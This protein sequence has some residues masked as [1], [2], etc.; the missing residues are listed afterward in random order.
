MNHHATEISTLTKGAIILGH[1]LIGWI[2]CG[3]LIG[4]GRQFMSMQTTLVMHAIGAPL[5]FIIISLHYFKRFAFTSPLQAAFLFLAVVIAMDVFV[6]A[7]LIEK[8]FAMFASPL[9]TWLPLALIFSS[10]HMTGVI[11]KHGEK[12]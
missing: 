8:S 4:I 5:G 3:T 9:G 6:V 7:M 10:T 1:A 2:Y 11:C 12:R